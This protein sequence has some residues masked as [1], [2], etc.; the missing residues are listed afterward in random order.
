MICHTTDS[1]G[2]S[3]V[4]LGDVTGDVDL[5]PTFAVPVFTEYWLSIEELEVALLICPCLLYS[6]PRMMF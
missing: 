6:D 2:L 4:A 1:N 3:G 5:V